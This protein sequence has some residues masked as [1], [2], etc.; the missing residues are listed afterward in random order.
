MRPSSLSFGAAG[1]N[2][3]THTRSRFRSKLPAL[4]GVSQQPRNLLESHPKRFSNASRACKDAQI[5]IQPLLPHV[6]YYG[7][8]RRQQN[9]R[10]KGQRVPFSFQPVLARPRTGVARNELPF[11][12][13]GVLSGKRLAGIGATLALRQVVPRPSPKKHSAV[14]GSLCWLRRPLFRAQ[15]API[16]K[17]AARHDPHFPLFPP[18]FCTSMLSREERGVAPL[19]H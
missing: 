11:P 19:P 10:E 3:T 1:A 4:S 15:T 2:A 12:R 5:S 18:A 16:S 7:K 14:R 6:R 17:E 13:S 8:G 9:R